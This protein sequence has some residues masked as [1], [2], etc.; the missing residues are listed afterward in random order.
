MTNAIKRN[1]I[2]LYTLNV[3]SRGWKLGIIKL[4]YS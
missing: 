4:C 3:L 2:I 1:V